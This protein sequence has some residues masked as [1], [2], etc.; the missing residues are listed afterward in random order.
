[1]REKHWNLFSLRFCI[2]FSNWRGGLSSSAQTRQGQLSVLRNRLSINISFLS[3]PKHTGK[4]YWDNKT[5][6]EILSHYEKGREHFSLNFL[7]NV[8]SK[9]DSFLSLRLH[10]LGLF[11]YIMY[12][13]SAYPTNRSQKFIWEWELNLGRKELGIYASCVRST[14]RT[15]IFF[16]RINEIKDCFSWKC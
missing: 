8:C 10:F 11:T 4:T 13:V 3:P 14:Y 12:S 2:F 1:M 5:F 7:K 6:F 15:R 9:G 16:V